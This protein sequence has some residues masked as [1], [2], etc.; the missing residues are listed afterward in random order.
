MAVAGSA[1]AA[2][3]FV[4]VGC[5]GTTTA[6][7][8][9]VEQDPEPSS[10]SSTSTGSGSESGSETD[11]GMTGGSSS[12]GK[13]MTATDGEMAVGGSGGDGSSGGSVGTGAGGDQGSDQGSSG[14]AGSGGE[15]GPVPTSCIWDTEP[16]PGD[17]EV[18]PGDA[19]A[20]LCDLGGGKPSVQ[21]CFYLASSSDS[22]DTLTYSTDDLRALVLSEFRDCGHPYSAGI[23]CGPVRVASDVGAKCC[24]EMDGT[25]QRDKEFSSQPR[26]VCAEEPSGGV[27]PS[28]PA[29][30][31]ETGVPHYPVVSRDFLYFPGDANQALCDLGG[32]RT[33]VHACVP[34]LNDDES[35]GDLVTNT[36]NLMQG[37]TASITCDG[38]WTA[39]ISCGPVRT[40]LASGPACCWGIDGHG[41]VPSAE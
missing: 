1:I 29:G 19:E 22:C 37:A 32:G 34:L 7:V 15:Q 27:A 17:F 28:S 33:V 9:N 16:K 36:D 14:A 10:Q 38:S 8:S 3:A 11:G 30:C 25:C 40:E 35:C 26:D 5:E 21:A 12:G 20:P 24:W 41:E 23:F 13:P 6:G 39:G 31:E 18:Q 4:L 2:L